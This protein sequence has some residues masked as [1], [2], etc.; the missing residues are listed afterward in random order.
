[1]SLDS[2]I[3]IQISRE[4]TA[5]T[6]AGFG[7]LAIIAEFQPDKTTT[8]F[9]RYRYYGS[10]SELT[11]DGWLT[12]DAVYKAAQIAFAQNPTISRIMVGRKAESGT[13]AD[14][15]TALTAIEAET[16]DWYGFAIMSTES[17]IVFNADFVADDS[18]VVTVDGQASSSVPFNTDH[19][20]T[21]DDIV[22]AIE[23]I[24]GIGTVT[25]EDIAGDTDNRTIDITVDESAANTLTV[26]VTNGGSGTAQGTA[27]TS[28][29]D[30]AQ[31]EYENAA[32]WAET[33]KKIF[34][35]CDDNADIYDAGSTTDIAAVTSAANYDRTAVI[36]HEDAQ[37]DLIP[38]WLETGWAGRLFPL[39][40]GQ[41][42]WKFKTI[43]GV[44]PSSLTT[45]Q[46]TAVENKNAN[47]YITVGGVNITQQGTVA[48]GEY[49]DVIRGVDWLEARIQE[50]IFTELVNAEKIPYTD[51][52]IQVIKSAL[53]SVL[54]LAIRRGVLADYE[55][56]APLASNISTADKLA[57]TL[58]DITFSGTL[59]GA[60][61]KVEVRGTVSV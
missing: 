28:I 5:V 51:G 20:T 44:S 7:T 11:D 23:A 3:D 57:R 13:D 26:A 17:R 41:A 22:T 29:T 55:S 24:T 27:Y 38:S 45:G 52:G 4:T 40:P 59:A 58:P 56:S 34:F 61:H 19:A 35:I 30:T 8:E 6:R 33:Q 25:A 16:S 60:I 10:L 50:A 42:T 31:S 1:M 49:I 43:A 54:D 37:G 12:S 21:M 32:V 14:F 36:Y 47:V 18:I 48:S 53:D 15:A 46:V 9:D 39:N 2:I